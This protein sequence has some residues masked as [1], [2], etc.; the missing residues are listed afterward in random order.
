[1]AHPASRTLTWAGFLLGFALGGFF[2]GILLHQILQWHHLLSNVDAVQDMR[3]QI[4]AD[5]LFHAL[6][7]VLAA[8]ALLLLWRARAATGEP[9][10]GRRLCGTALVGFGAWH[11][12]DGVLSHWILGIHRIRMDSASPLMWDLIWFVGFG[13]LPALVGGWMLRKA[14]S[15][16]SGGGRMAAASLGLAALLAGPI[17]L[18]PDG[19]QTRQTMVLFAPGVSSAQ[20]FNALAE[21]DAR[22][23]WV[24]RHGGLWAVKMQEPAAAWRLYRSGAMWVS[25]S[26]LAFG[27]LA[28]TRT[29]DAV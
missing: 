4:M 18:W 14:G 19:S 15:G 21:V 28:W 12:I 22:V 11:M 16:S 7:Y 27:C 23:V 26:G 24:D 2:D 17:A 10:A 9:G 13:V 1:M 3:L 25:N 8:I 5:G 29:P 6:M 20:A